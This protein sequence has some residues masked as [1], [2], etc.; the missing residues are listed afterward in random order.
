MSIDRIL[1]DKLIFDYEQLGKT[2]SQ[3]DAL[4]PKDVVLNLT[5]SDNIQNA[6]DSLSDTGGILNFAQGIYSVNPVLK[7]RNKLV[8]FRANGTVSL[9]GFTAGLRTGNV[10]FE[11]IQFNNS[12][13][14]NHVQLGFDQNTMKL[15]EEVPSGFTFSKCQFNG[16]TRR[17]IY[18]NCAD[19]LVDECSFN[20]YYQIGSD[21]QAI[22][23]SNG[24]RNHVIRNSN[25]EAASENIMY[26]GADAA[27]E[28]MYPRDV[29]IEGCNFTK[30]EAWKGKGYAMKCL[31]EMK[32]IQGLTIRRN[33]F[34]G[35]W[36]DAWGNA[37][38]I[39]LKSANQGGTNP[40]ARTTNVLIE[41]N[42]IENV[43]TYLLLVGKDDG[44][45]LSGTMKDILIKNNLFKNMNAEPDG[46]SLA[47][48]DG[49]VNLILD[50]NTFF[51]NRH[52]MLEWWGPLPVDMVYRN[53]IVFHGEY[54]AHPNLPIEVRFEYNAV[55]IDPRRKIPLPASNVYYSNVKVDLSA[56]V[57]SDGLKVGSSLT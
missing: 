2:I 12:I 15:P 53:N 47:I 50:H 26:G 21:S 38:A 20:D 41:E 17:G 7:Y 23:G 57:T 56:H 40:T 11:G 35:C 5:P 3:I 31:L 16:P 30:K 48:A 33:K 52:S 51:N 8:V 25:L 43:G 54:G 24:C 55:Q 13:G 4:V 27:S 6:L 39:V 49:P 36:K 42:T 10:S 1:I 29:L 44:P 32:N 18:V 28:L 22:S 34:N 14:V 9:R 19:L 45:Y 46:R 37:P